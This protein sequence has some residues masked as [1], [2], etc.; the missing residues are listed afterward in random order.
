MN[1]S[2]VLPNIDR[3][4]ECAILSFLFIF[5]IEWT[6]IQIFSHFWKWLCAILENNRKRFNKSFITYILILFT[7]ISCRS[8]VLLLSRDH[9]IFIF[10]YLK[11]IGVILG[12]MT[13]DLVLVS[14]LSFERGS[15]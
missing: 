13:Y 2:K 10:S 8:Y 5:L 6:S 1:F 11:V 12:L 15:R 3:E 14:V 4:L 7:D 9:T